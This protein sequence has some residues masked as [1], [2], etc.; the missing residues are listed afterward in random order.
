MVLM[1]NNADLY[2]GAMRRRKGSR[3]RHGRLLPPQSWGPALPVFLH[4]LCLVL[5]VSTTLPSCVR[6]P[7]KIGKGNCPP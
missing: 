7:W 1:L 3:R 2:L 5:L 6:A 4:L